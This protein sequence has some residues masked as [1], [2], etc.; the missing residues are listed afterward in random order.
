MEFI[1][2]TDKEDVS[3]SVD[4]LVNML[5]NKLISTPREEF[6]WLVDSL[7]SFLQ[8]RETMSSMTLEQLSTISF[9]LGY[10]YR[11][12]LEKNDVILGEQSEEMANN[13]NG[14]PSGTEDNSRSS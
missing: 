6:P 3:F 2:K 11:V 10:F 1:L 12:F 4:Q 7:C 5:M 8:A 14:E 13:P 9:S